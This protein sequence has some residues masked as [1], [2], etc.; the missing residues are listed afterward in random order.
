MKVFYDSP[1]TMHIAKNSV[2]HERTTHIEID[3]HFIQERL[4]NGDLALSYLSTT[5][6]PV[7]LFTKALGFKQFLHLRDRLGMSNPHAST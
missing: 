3:C 7:D 2:F 1:D 4:V 6:Q 5:Q